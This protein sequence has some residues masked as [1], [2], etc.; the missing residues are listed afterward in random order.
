MIHQDLPSTNYSRLF[1]TLSDPNGGSYRQVLTPAA[2]VA[3]QR[4]V[5]S[6][7]IGL[8]FYSQVVPSA[9]VDLAL[10]MAAFHWLSG[11]VPDGCGFHDEVTLM[12]AR[13]STQRQAFLRHARNDWR[14][15]LLLRGR[16]MKSGALLVMS[17]L[18]RYPDEEYTENERQGQLFRLM[19]Q[20]ARE[21]QSEQLLTDE[22]F[23]SFTF[24]EA[25]RTV[26][27]WL[28][29]ALL[30]EVG[31]E[32]VAQSI[33]PSPPSVRGAEE[34]VEAFGRRI[35]GLTRWW[36][37][38]VL[39]ATL[40]DRPAVERAGLIDSFYARLGGA[41]S[42]HVAAPGAQLE[43]FNRCHLLLRRL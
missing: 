37:E 42:K 35:A 38:G 20:T 1:E 2:E 41:I 23:D 40:A 39:G 11:D 31:F 36:S 24:P 16:E 9:S 43:N 22:E 29:S 15:L 18:M 4:N 7:A 17:N 19:A 13:D 32:V 26:H 34:D 25:I 10:S 27:E 8:S 30:T 14:H 12:L 3:G 21:L 6:F 5:F 33:S 28:D